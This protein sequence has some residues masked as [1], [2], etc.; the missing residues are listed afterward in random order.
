MKR[1][2]ESH[3]QHGSKPHKYNPTFRAGTDRGMEY[4]SDGVETS[5]AAFLVSG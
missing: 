3:D 2:H 1:K 4:S 5:I